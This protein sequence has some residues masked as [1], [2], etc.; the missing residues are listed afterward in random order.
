[1]SRLVKYGALLCLSL[2]LFSGI[3]KADT[4]L[5]PNGYID[6]QNKVLPKNNQQ[7][8]P[9]NVEDT[10]S[11]EASRNAD[12]KKSK[13]KAEETIDKL[14]S[15]QKA[16]E[17]S[18]RVDKIFSN[19][20]P[21]VEQMAQA[22]RDIELVKTFVSDKSNQSYKDSDQFKGLE[23][24]ISTYDENFV[25][26]TEE[27]ETR[28]EYD[29]YLDNAK[30]SKDPSKHSK[31]TS[32][33]FV[34]EG[35]FGTKDVFPRAVNA[36]VQGLFFIVKM[37]YILTMIILEQIFSKTVYDQLDNIVRTSS[38]LFNQLMIDYRYPIFGLAL[39]GGLV[40]LIKKKRFP[41]SSFKFLLVWFLALFLYS[42][43]TLPNNYGNKDITADYNISRIIK[44]VDGLSTA[45]TKSAVT[46]FDTLEGKPNAI[47][48]T[49]NKDNI[50][51]VRDAIFNQMVYEPF[52][53]LNFSQEP[54]KITETKVK[55]LLRTGGK[56]DKVDGYQKTNKKIT[57]LSFSDIGTKF[58]VS[59]ASL[60]RALVVGV[61]LICLG[62]IS[63][64]FKYL[65]MILLLFLVII[66]F[67][68]MLPNGEHL[69]TGVF[70]KILQF[71]FIGGL[72]LFF[73][74]VF[75]YINSLIESLAYGLSGTFIWSSII[76]GLIW[77]IIWYFRRLL[78]GVFVRGTVSAQE[79]SRRAQ[80]SLDR[81]PLTKRTVNF[82]TSKHR[83][84]RKNGQEEKQNLFAK[85]SESNSEQVGRFTTL[86]RA[87]SN[88]FLKVGNH[89]LNDFD[90]LRY[91]DSEEDILEAKNRRQNFKQE[92]MD[93]KDQL[94]YQV[95]RP[96]AY[97]IRS[98]VHDLAG[99]ENMPSQM[100]HRERQRK[101][102]ER[103]ERKELNRKNQSQ[104]AG[105]QNERSSLFRSPEETHFSKADLFNKK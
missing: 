34:E 36:L 53:A 51:P 98:K 9:A 87:S 58:I 82:E 56:S 71:V 38:G 54:A 97:G 99:N 88:G 102:F 50:K 40:E 2:F 25:K 33:I 68:A 61:A 100:I 66:L 31:L 13:Q 80:D 49:T 7:Y 75:L 8:T 48:D 4:T 103:Q 95:T 22:S 41:F 62:L 20:K 11:Q 76:Q 15:Y 64:V 78:A 21:T 89:L 67:M 3:V 74:R 18:I 42:K 59:I 85:P 45:F 43:S 12:A 77:F 55:D 35:F 24:T 37:I 81:M 26:L 16:L 73:I 94:H 5:T 104:K 60:V 72:G 23:Q 79:L 44:Y 69:L 17:A 92:I 1:M 6:T 84:L 28:E 29:H 90:H 86:K 63:L 83:S 101:L 27:A 57:R 30:A 19:K 10:K 46:S 91:G 105:I 32:Y 96:L 47:G 39:L 52:I 14:A 70:K 65:A 93:K